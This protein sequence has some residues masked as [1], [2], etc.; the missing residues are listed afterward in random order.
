VSA[1][2]SWAG[3]WFERLA[4]PAAPDTAAW[5]R[6]VLRVESGVPTARQRAARYPH[7]LERRLDLARRLA[8][9]GEDAEAD[10]ILSQTEAT[11]PDRA[12]V[13]L[14]RAERSR[15][16]DPGA[17]LAL[18]REVVAAY[19]GNGEAHFLVGRLL[20]EVADGNESGERTRELARGHLLTAADRLPRRWDAQ[21]LAAGILLVDD[22]PGDAERYI[23]AA[24][25]QRP[26]DAATLLA[27]ARTALGN[28]DPGLA[29][30]RLRRLIR[31]HPR[32]RR[33]YV[34]LAGLLASRG[35]S[36]GAS[37]VLRTG[38]EATR[39]STAFPHPR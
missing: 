17:A 11:D 5:V 30:R 23:R 29:E 15:I 4:W 16:A 27:G 19:P 18:G 9:A 39:D 21:Y 8:A 12:D 20:L 28:Q 22:R 26:D 24:L 10:A 25:R 1:D 6:G 2:S 35:D 36:P 7:D 33:G 34:G 32:D 31:H 38:Y 14:F 3:V 13:R 37:E